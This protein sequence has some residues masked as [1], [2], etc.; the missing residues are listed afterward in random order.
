M[1]SPCSLTWGQPI[2]GSCTIE[3]FLI[4]EGDDKEAPEWDGLARVSQ[5]VEFV[6]G[7]NFLI[8]TAELYFFDVIVSVL[9][10]SRLLVLLGSI[11]G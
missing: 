2:T 5:E 7:N 4:P 1:S 11:S 10:S 9:W 6:S 8:L 3:A